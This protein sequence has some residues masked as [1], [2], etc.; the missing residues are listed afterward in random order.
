MNALSVEM[1]NGQARHMRVSK[2]RVFDLSDMGQPDSVQDDFGMDL[3]VNYDPWWTEPQIPKGG[4][5]RTNPTG[6]RANLQPGETYRATDSY[7]PAQPMTPN[8][9]ERNL[10][11]SYTQ[12]PIK[13]LPHQ[14][15]PGSFPHGWIPYEELS[16][17]VFPDTPPRPSGWVGIPK[18]SDEKK[19]AIDAVHPE[20]WLPDEF[21]VYDV[22]GGFGSLQGAMHGMHGMRGMGV[23]VPPSV[24]TAVANDAMK[25]G[26]EAAAAGATPSDVEKAIAAVIDIGS[27]AGALYLQK[28]AMDEQADLLKKQQAAAAAQQAV[29]RGPA[30]ATLP[31]SGG[32]SLTTPLVIGGGLA[33]AATIA[34]LL[35]SKKKK[36]GRR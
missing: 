11:S 36:G 22:S 30:T 17:Q 2:R 33:L 7:R 26:A 27:Q 10:P 28:R 4:M 35:L 31:P 1:L 15:Y 16:P 21:Q 25:A 5:P 29:N 23:I 19:R 34:A 9:D 6:A 20:P 8:N 3:S 32:S 12:A 14:N 18:L 24:T 13:Q